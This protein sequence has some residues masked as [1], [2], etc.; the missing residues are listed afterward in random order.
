MGDSANWGWRLAF[1]YM[2]VGIKSDRSVSATSV[3]TTD[4][5]ALGGVI[6]P[7]APYM[8]T[9]NGPGPLIDDTPSRSFSS[10]TSVVTGRHEVDADVFGFHVGPYFEF[11]INDRFSFNLS[12]GLAL[13][14]VNSEFRFSESAGAGTVSGSKS[15]MDAVFGGY[16]AANV[17]YALNERWNLVVGAEYEGLT[18]FKQRAN[19]REA[20]IEFLTGVSAKAGLNFSF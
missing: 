16:V 11:P 7:Q 8:G 15:K 1:G 3:T 6:P 4:T 17:V 2:N 19:G 10:A 12:S 18:D 14:M 5:Y 20:K 9:F 13:G